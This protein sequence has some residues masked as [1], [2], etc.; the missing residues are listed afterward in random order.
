[1]KIRPISTSLEDYQR[2]VAHTRGNE[3][4]PVRITSRNAFGPGGSTY[5][6]D[7][8]GGALHEIVSPGD[9]FATGDEVAVERT[10]DAGAFIVIRGFSDVARRP[11]QGAQYGMTDVTG[12][13]TI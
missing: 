13:N 2:N 3:F 9:D 5:E 4:R 10:G 6:A 7:D 12:E 1:M 8:A 11:T